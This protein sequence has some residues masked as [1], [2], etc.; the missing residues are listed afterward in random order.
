MLSQLSRCP[1]AE[2]Q[3][4]EDQWTPHAVAHASHKPSQLPTV[5]LQAVLVGLSTGL[6]ETMNSGPFPVLSLGT[7]YLVVQSTGCCCSCRV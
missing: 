6:Q 7:A 1:T 4:L 5:K 2:V 3:P